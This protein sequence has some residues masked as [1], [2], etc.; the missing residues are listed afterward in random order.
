VDSLYGITL[1]KFSLKL[2][3]NGAVVVCLS[4][5]HREKKGIRKRTLLSVNIRFWEYFFTEAPLIM[6]HDH[7]NVKNH[8]RW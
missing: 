7:F 1:H 6:I 2:N 5:I 8:G 3:G 4:F